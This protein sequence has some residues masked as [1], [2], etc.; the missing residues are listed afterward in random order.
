MHIYGPNDTYPF[1]VNM[2]RTTHPYLLADFYDAFQF[3]MINFANV[4]IEHYS[5]DPVISLFEN[6]Q[7]MFQYM[8]YDVTCTVLSKFV[9]LVGQSDIFSKCPTKNASVPDQMSDKNFPTEKKISSSVICNPQKKCGGLGKTKINVKKSRIRRWNK[10]KTKQNTK[11]IAQSGHSTRL[12]IPP[13]VSG[14]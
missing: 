3:E 8:K 7:I 1:V 5:S 14:T 4:N 10:L 11:Q 13:A 9:G 6:K 2:K 12:E